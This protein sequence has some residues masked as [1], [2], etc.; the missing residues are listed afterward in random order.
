MIILFKYD[1]IRQLQEV[2]VAPD[3]EFARVIDETLNILF[4][5]IDIGCCELFTKLMHKY[6]F[7]KVHVF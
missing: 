4:Y 6:F 1:H 7:L 2:I 3:V 5:K